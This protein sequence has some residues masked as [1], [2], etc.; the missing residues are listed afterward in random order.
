MKSLRSRRLFERRGPLDATLVPKPPIATCLSP[1]K[2]GTRFPRRPLRPDAGAVDM[3]RR[4]RRHRPGERHE[5]RS[6]FD[7]S[8]RHRRDPHRLRRHAPHS[9]RDLPREHQ[10][11]GKSLR[12]TGSSTPRTEIW[13]APAAGT[14]VVTI[15]SGE[16]NATTFTHLDIVATGCTF[17][18]NAAVQGGAIDASGGALVLRDCRFEGNTSAGSAGCSQMER[19][20][21]CRTRLWPPSPPEGGAH[22]GPCA[23]PAERARVTWPRGPA[24]GA[25]RSLAARL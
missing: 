12:L 3:A 8:V 6:L 19:A 18:D 23:M 11:M 5:P 25:P 20:W 24:R 4:R 13:G 1:S 17:T 22:C 10:L 16:T 15:A 9:R 7:D 21:A 14:R 2:R